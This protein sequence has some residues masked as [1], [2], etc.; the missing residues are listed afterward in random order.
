AYDAPWQRQHWRSIQAAYGNAPFFDHYA[1]DIRPFYERRWEFLFD[2][3]L[4]IQA[5]V[6]KKKLGWAGEFVFQTEFF[7]AGEWP[8]G[9]DLRSEMGGEMGNCPA[10]FS[11]LP[12]PQVFRERTGFLPNLSVLDLLFCVGKTGGEVLGQNISGSGRC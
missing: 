7:P 6:L 4:E 10:W 8:Q 2:Y 1:D 11:P 5:F 12:Y 3:N 9:A